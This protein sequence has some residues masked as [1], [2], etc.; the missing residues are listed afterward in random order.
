MSKSDQQPIQAISDEPSKPPA[1]ETSVSVWTF[2]LGS[3]SAANSKL[4]PEHRP[5]FETGAGLYPASNTNPV[6]V[7]I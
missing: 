7:A 4:A 6:D 3:S 1:F 2:I 5:E